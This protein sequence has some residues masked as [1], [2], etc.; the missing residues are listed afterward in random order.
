M[1]FSRSCLAF[2]VALVV[3]FSPL[4]AGAQTWQKL[5]GGGSSGILTPAD[6][7]NG[8]EINVQRTYTCSWLFA[9][10]STAYARIYG[11]GLQVR[12]TQ[13][14]PYGAVSDSGWVNLARPFKRVM[15]LQALDG[16][17]NFQES[18]ISVTILSISYRVR[19]AWTQFS[20]GGCGALT[21]YDITADQ[22]W[23]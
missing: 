10:T 21:A 12:E 4:W 14:T 16:C 9:C 22:P 19:G 1:P 8:T 6:P 18:T 3:S 2:L 15:Q 11:G 7:V 20:M 23:P 13:A 17:G 5:G